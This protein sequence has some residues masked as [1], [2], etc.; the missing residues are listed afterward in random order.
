MAF[1]DFT[2]SFGKV[3][4][5]ITKVIER[6]KKI[7]EKNIWVRYIYTYTFVATKKQEGKTLYINKETGETYK[8]PLTPIEEEI[9]KRWKREGVLIKKKE[10]LI[11][12][13]EGRI[14]SYVIRDFAENEEFENNIE[15]T[16]EL[17]VRNTNASV[18]KRGGDQTYSFIFDI[19]NVLSGKEHIREGQVKKTAHS[20]R[21]DYLDR[22]LTRSEMD[23]DSKE[24]LG[25]K[26]PKGKVVFF[27]ELFDHTFN[28]SVFKLP[29]V[30]RNDYFT[31]TP[32]EI[33]K[34]LERI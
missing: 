25:Y 11:R 7:F 26:A 4:G 27:V 21:Y 6:T 16:F 14:I 20:W 23:I 28:R 10:V 18:R 33:I 31:L 32:K 17:I 30:I 9:L 24:V 5:Y 22:P 3:A 1:I 2:R 19:P 15:D 8:R 12:K 29:L 13:L 34:S